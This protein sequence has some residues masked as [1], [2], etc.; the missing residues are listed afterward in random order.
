M[1]LI[2]FRDWCWWF[3]V[4]S[5]YYKEGKT[6][7]ENLL[8]EERKVKSD[9]GSKLSNISNW[10]EEALKISRFQLDSFFTFS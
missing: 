5:S 10:K 9:H 3:R 8:K 6:V 4:R 1:S 2:T 7:N